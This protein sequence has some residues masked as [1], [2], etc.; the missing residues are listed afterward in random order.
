MGS[1][2][3]GDNYALCVYSVRTSWARTS[4][5]R[6]AHLLLEAI[7]F[8]YQKYETKTQFIIAI[9]FFGDFVICPSLAILVYT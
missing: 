8:T 9:L 1:E 2:N 6:C 4:W 3:V 7:L 5:A